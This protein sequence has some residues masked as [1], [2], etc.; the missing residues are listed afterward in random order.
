MGAPGVYR[1]KLMAFAGASPR[2]TPSRAHR[3]V[4][5][6]LVAAPSPSLHLARRG[7]R[8]PARLSEASL[9]DPARALRVG[10][11]KMPERTN[12]GLRGL[13]RI[14]TSVDHGSENAPLLN[15]EAASRDKKSNA[16]SRYVVPALGG[17][18]PPRPLPRLLRAILAGTVRPLRSEYTPRPD[19][20][21]PPGAPR[22]LPTSVHASLPS[23]ARWCSP[24]SPS[25]RRTTPLSPRAGTTR[26]PPWT[27]RTRARRSPP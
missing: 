4:R 23:Q 21:P 11:A 14:K 22:L 6:E 24:W 1:L 10:P 8:G 15:R 19:A 12:S 27:P 18:C 16:M 26:S 9:L 25:P 13:P 5:R 20:R 2:L 7:A 17:A 3:P